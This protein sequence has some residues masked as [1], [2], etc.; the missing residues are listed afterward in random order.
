MIGA[1]Q[2]RTSFDGADRTVV[3]GIMD[4]QL[5]HLTLIMDRL[6]Q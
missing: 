2:M 5:C 3:L 1:T 6:R 4:R